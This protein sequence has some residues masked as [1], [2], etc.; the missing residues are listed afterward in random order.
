MTSIRDKDWQCFLTHTL[1]CNMPAVH[2][3]QKPSKII[4]Y[5]RAMLDFDS[6]QLNFVICYQANIW[7]HLPSEPHTFLLHPKDSI[8]LHC[9]CTCRYTSDVRGLLGLVTYLSEVKVSQ[10]SV[11]LMKHSL[12]NLIS[13]FYKRL[14]HFFQERSWSH[15]WIHS[16]FI[17]C[18][19]VWMLDWVWVHNT[20]AAGVRCFAVSQTRTA[21][22]PRTSSWFFPTSASGWASACGASWERTGRALRSGPQPPLTSDSIKSA[23]GGSP[24]PNKQYSSCVTSS[25]S[26]VLTS[27]PPQHCWTRDWLTTLGRSALI[28][29][30]SSL[31]TVVK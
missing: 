5:Q 2:I 17:H 13:Y 20:G 22:A 29:P 1:R 6:L 4:R 10:R 8:I 3:T 11:C 15:L 25:S 9:T 21:Q 27:S 12:Q 19:S 14:L 30:T 31:R 28:L 24:P 23:I 26:N 18:M 16:S 7:S